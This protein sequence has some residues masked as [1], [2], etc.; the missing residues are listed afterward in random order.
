MCIATAAALNK[1]FQNEPTAICVTPGLAKS[2]LLSEVVMYLVRVL[3]LGQCGYNL[4]NLLGHDF[5]AIIAFLDI[6]FD[7]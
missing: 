6:P 3:P 5:L 7:F 2:E 1:Q 4:K